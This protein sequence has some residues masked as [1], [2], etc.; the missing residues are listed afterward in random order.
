M[1]NIPNGYEVVTQSIPDGYEVVGESIADEPKFITNILGEKVPDTTQQL[2][3]LG[4]GAMKGFADVGE[5]VTSLFGN[6]ENPVSKE[7]QTSADYWEGSTVRPK[8]AAVGEFAADE[9]TGIAT[10]ASAG[11]IFD[12]LNDLRR[13]A[14]GKNAIKKIDEIYEDIVRAIGTDKA[15]AALAVTKPIKEAASDGSWKPKPFYGSPIEVSAKNATVKVKDA[16]ADSPAVRAVMGANN[17]PS[18]GVPSVQVAERLFGKKIPIIS[19]A[20]DIMGGLINKA[21]PFTKSQAMSVRQE[22]IDTMTG[23]GYSS[24]EALKAFNDYVTAESKLGNRVGTATGA[25]LG[26]STA[27]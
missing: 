19:D 1:S 4:R 3:D 5:S 14:I 12:K 6:A 25:L 22:F 23:K 13:T 11:K 26:G 20:S 15:E 17:V 8:A 2:Q 27:N 9:L 24:K 21:L 18:T 16:L 7:F 10:G